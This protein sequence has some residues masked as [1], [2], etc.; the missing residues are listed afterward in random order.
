MSACWKG[1]NNDAQW[2]F[3][4]PIPVSLKTTSANR[5]SDRD[6]DVLYDELDRNNFRVSRWFV[7]IHGHR[8]LHRTFVSELDCILVRN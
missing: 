5:D 1:R 4:S 6:E 8:A 2:L 3:E 7:W